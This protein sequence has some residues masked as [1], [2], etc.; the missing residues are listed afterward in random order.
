MNGEGLVTFLHSSRWSDAW[1]L[2]IFLGILVAVVPAIL[3]GSALA[4]ATPPPGGGAGHFG[5]GIPVYWPYHAILMSAGFLLLFSGFL[6]A[7][8]HKTGNWYKTHRFLETTGGACV[9]TGLFIGV[10]MVALS[11][12]PHLRNIHEVLG[13]IVGIVLIGTMALGYFITRAGKSG[14]TVRK[15]HRWLGRISLILVAINIALGVF[16]LS[17]IL[18]R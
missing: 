13:A 11:G 14:N 1:E 16:F 6:V 18:R 9:I 3:C 17:M 7:R 15:S 10:Y 8:Y 2:K 4:Q 12:L 5:E